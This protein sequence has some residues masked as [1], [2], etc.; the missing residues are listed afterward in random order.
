MTTRA[1]GRR[2]VGVL[3]VAI[4][5]LL[6]VPGHASAD[7][8]YPVAAGSLVFGALPGGHGYRIHFSEWERQGRRRFKAVARGRG[9]IVT[10]QVPVGSAPTEGIAANLGRRGRFDLHLRRTGKPRRLRFGKGCEGEPGRWWR[11]YL[12]GSARFRGERGYAEAQARRIPVVVESWKAF[13]CHYAG[14]EQHRGRVRRAQVYAHRGPLGFGAVLAT[15][16][17]A[18]ADERAIFRAWTSERA[19]RMRIYREVTAPAP[20]STFA[21][22]GGPKLPE[23]VTVAP[24]KPF[25]GSATFARTPESTFTWTGDLSVEFPGLGPVRLAGPRFAA[26][27]CAL[28]GCVREEPEREPP[29]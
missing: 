14:G 12:V 6:G 26:G 1:I 7:G 4:A 17:S 3:A 24:P 18:P 15:R 25:A 8:T 19:G 27:V 23:V 11:G 29:T 28:R 21:F 13:R 2:R 22:P 16:H 5:V 9:A 10:Y 20:E